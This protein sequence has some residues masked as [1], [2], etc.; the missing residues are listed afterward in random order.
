M[1]IDTDTD[2]WMLAPMT[3]RTLTKGVLRELHNRMIDDRYENA[4]DVK[5]F[6]AACAVV[7]NSCQVLNRSMDRGKR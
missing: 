2:I 6:E 1:R 4:I 5:R 7:N 3:L